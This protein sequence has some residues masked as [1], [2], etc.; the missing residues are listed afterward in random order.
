MHPFTA[1]PSTQIYWS[2]ARKCANDRSVEHCD[3]YKWEGNR[4]RRDVFAL[5]LLLKQ[6][7]WDFERQRGIE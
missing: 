4:F 2:G 7:R 3:G 5:T 1:V 6:R